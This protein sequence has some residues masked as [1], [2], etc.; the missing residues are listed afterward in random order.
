MS[1]V[2][3]LPDVL[4]FSG[5]VL[6]KENCESISIPNLTAIIPDLFCLKAVAY[7]FRKFSNSP[8][9]HGELDFKVDQTP[10]LRTLCD[11]SIW[12]LV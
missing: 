12:S 5:N 9:R 11:A 4:C 2:L 3:L 10:S 6:Q 7:F 1:F 8:A